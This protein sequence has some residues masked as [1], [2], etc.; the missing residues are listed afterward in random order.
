M[1][2]GLVVW[3]SKNSLAPNRPK[4]AKARKLKKARNSP[5][6]AARLAALGF[7]SPRERDS[8]ALTPT[9]VP[10]DTAIS[11][12]W[13]GNAMDTAVRAAWLIMDTN[14][15]STILYRACTSIEIIM[16]RDMD[17]SSLLMGMTPILFSWDIV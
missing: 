12:F 6:T 4:T 10:A 14:T 7:F 13:M 17:I 9:Q 5:L 15:L 2:T 1:M 8:R 3:L 11:R 16:G